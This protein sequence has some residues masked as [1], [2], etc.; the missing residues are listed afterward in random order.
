[1]SAGCGEVVGVV[2]A[3]IRN[4]DDFEGEPVW[5]LLRRQRIQRIAD[6]GMRP[7]G[8]NNDGK[9]HRRVEGPVL[10]RVVRFHYKLRAQHTGCGLCRPQQIDTSLTFSGSSLPLASHA[11]LHTPVLTDFSPDNLAA[12]GASALA[13]SRLAGKP[14]GARCVHQLRRGRE[15]RGLWLRQAPWAVE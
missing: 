2:G 4:H 14:A 7:M 8:G 1:L 12:H 11:M 3:V 15:C 5:L 9:T 6:E 13:A 10:K